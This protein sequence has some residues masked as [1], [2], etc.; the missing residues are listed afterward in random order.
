MKHGIQ[1]EKRKKETPTNKERLK[2]PSL[3]YG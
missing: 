2:M 3:M 1:K